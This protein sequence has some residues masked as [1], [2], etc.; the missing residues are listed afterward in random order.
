MLP[1]PPQQVQRKQCQVSDE[2]EKAHKPKYY[3]AHQ[4]NLRLLFQKFWVVVMLLKQ[5]PERDEERRKK[6][7]V[8]YIYEYANNTS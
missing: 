3:V 4:M 5:Q 6:D 2:S 8:N 1:S 7:C